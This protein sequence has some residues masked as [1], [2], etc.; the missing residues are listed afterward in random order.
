MNVLQFGFGD[1]MPCSPYLP[2]NHTSNAVVYTGTHDNNTTV[3]WYT[4]LSPSERKNF[5]EYMGIKI[6][7]KNISGPLCRMAYSSVAAL[8]I[9]PMQDVLSLDESARMNMPATAEGNWAW[10]LDSSLLTSS[11]EDKLKRWVSYFNR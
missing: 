6:N 11:I 5:S 4:H 7:N 3:E 2:H 10:P 1:D 8:A 9:L